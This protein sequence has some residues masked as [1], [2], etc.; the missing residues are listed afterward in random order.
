MWSIPITDND[1]ALARSHRPE[2]VCVLFAASRVNHPLRA[3]P[4]RHRDRWDLLLE[5]IQSRQAASRSDTA[6]TLAQTLS[7]GRL[8]RRSRSDTCSDA[9]A[10]TLAQ[11]LSLGRLLRRSHSDAGSDA[12]ARTLAQTLSLGRLLIRSRLDAH[13]STLALQRSSFHARA[14]TLVLGSSRTSLHVNTA[15]CITVR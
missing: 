10:R 5:Y 1:H 7:L 3:G 4:Q 13:T 8:L 14:S 2:C 15:I 9:L 11:T 12:L 6:R